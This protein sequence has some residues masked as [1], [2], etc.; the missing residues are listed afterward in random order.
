MTCINTIPSTSNTLKNLVV[1]KSVH[2]S[3]IQTEFNAKKKMI[4][5]IFSAYVVPLLKD[6]NY[7][8]LLQEWKL[9]LGAAVSE[10]NIDVNM[11]KPSDKK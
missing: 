6:I 3:C 10:I 7:T 1:I 5:N 8:E 4:M 11:S 9:N 2:Y